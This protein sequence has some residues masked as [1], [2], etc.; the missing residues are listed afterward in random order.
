[1]K[2]HKKL[3]IV[4]WLIV[5]FIFF[6]LIYNSY[7]TEYIDPP[8]RYTK[9]DAQGNDLPDSAE[10]WTMVRDN[11]NKLVWEVK[12]DDG[13]IHDKDNKYTW[14]DSNP[15][16]NGG[17]AGTPGN[18]TD[19]EDFIRELNESRFGGYVDWRLPNK[20]ELQKIILSKQPYI[21]KQ[22]FVN[23]MSA[24]YWSST[25]YAIS[26]GY[27]WGV[28]FGYGYGYGYNQDK[29]SSYYVRA[30]REGQSRSFDN[31][32]ILKPDKLSQCLVGGKIYISWEIDERISNVKISISRKDGNIYSYETI[33]DSTENDGQHEWIVNGRK[34][35][36]SVIKIE[37]LV[38]KSKFSTSE[39]FTIYSLEEMKLTADKIKIDIYEMKWI[40]LNKNIVVYPMNI[41]WF[42]DDPQVQ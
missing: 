16:T 35:H 36:Y 18:G 12:T 28:N 33:V 3:T 34:S 24:F 22:Y 15:K 27:A 30:V 13:S 14:Y 11:E 2:T 40:D 6:N 32:V 17:K 9:L 7:A 29:D 23:N 5:V 4:S 21:D 31:L 8:P 37:S 42:C 25:I 39:R 20:G 38:D 26:I 1:M 10:E 19:T 41:Q